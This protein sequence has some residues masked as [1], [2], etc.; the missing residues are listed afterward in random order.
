MDTIGYPSPSNRRWYGCIL[1]AL[2]TMLVIPSPSLAQ[3]HHDVNLGT[4]YSRSPDDDRWDDRFGYPAVDGRVFAL[5]RD[6]HGNLYAGG[7]F[8]LAGAGIEVNNVG[9]WDGTGWNALGEGFGAPGM[10]VDALAVDDEGQLFAVTGISWEWDK[11]NVVRWDGSQWTVLGEVAGEATVLALDDDGRLYVGGRFSSVDGTAVENIAMWD[12]T[13]WSA[14]GVGT[15]RPVRAIASDRDGNV[16]VGGEFWSAGGTTA[17]Y[18]AKWN[19]TTWNALGIGMDANVNSL[20]IGHNGVLYAGGL[21]SKAGG[22][23][24]QSVARWDGVRWSAV[25]EVIASGNVEALAMDA[26]GTLYAGLRDYQDDGFAVSTWDGTA[27]TNIGRPDNRVIAMVVED[28]G[29]LI[30]AGTFEAID[31]LAAPYLARWDGMSWHRFG[32]LGFHT[33]VT[34]FAVG[35]DGVLVGSQ[36]DLASSADEQSY[37]ALIPVW[38]GEA[39]TQLRVPWKYEGHTIDCDDIRFDDDGIMYTSARDYSEG[40]TLIARWGGDDWQALGEP[41]TGSLSL[42][43]LGADGGVH[44]AMWVPGTTSYY[45]ASWDGTDWT[46]IATWENGRVL[47]LAVDESGTLYVA[48]RFEG[49]EDVEASNIAR[50]DG[51]SWSALG[52][53]TNWR[54]TA[55]TFDREGHLVAGG[56]FTRAGSLEAARVAKWDGVS[57]SALGDGL[58]GT[59]IAFAQDERGHLYAGGN[60]R[61]SGGVA[62][63]NLARWDG[64]SWSAIGSGTNGPVK[65]LTVFD[66]HLYAGGSF[67]MAGGKPS[68]FFARYA[69]PESPPVRVED[70]DYIPNRGFVLEQNHP[71]PFN[72]TTTLTYQLPDA[73]DVRLS[74]FDLLGRRVA[75]LVDDYQAPG[76]HSVIFDASR[77]P[78]GTYLYRI[79]AGKHVASRMMILA[80]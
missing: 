68:G 14:L 26:D 40:T 5:V 70:D 9:R 47:A 33:E 73:A 76:N 60:F 15:D 56:E 45:V 65:A 53:G 16:Y 67:T 77:L 11:S 55:L 42:F 80:K 43:A 10:N 7:S 2:T 28:S 31:A 46:I 8:L 71:N 37:D 29:E 58:D 64:T 63:D 74:V 21:F 49:V 6:E 61:M 78:S 17:N 66:R 52:E 12:G 3:V 19:G 72:P 69:I 44:V 62:V 1:F 30:V 38:A 20:I 27:W 34:A 51:A 22:N 36:Y 48:G 57:W 35:V 13:Q 75:V 59:V 25:G 79:T 4:D 54:V 24:A 18:V 41:L 50:W 32:G 23:A 39:W